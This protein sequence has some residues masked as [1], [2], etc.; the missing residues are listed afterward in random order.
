MFAIDA[1][2]PAS[3]DAMSF[4]HI[5]KLLKHEYGIYGRSLEESRRASA[6]KEEFISSL[7][8]SIDELELAF[9]LIEEGNVSSDFLTE[10]FENRL[11]FLS[12]K[13]AGLVGY[14]EGLRAN[15]NGNAL[16]VGVINE[17][18]PK[19]KKMHSLFVEMKLYVMEARS[20]MESPI[21]Q[22]F[23]SLDDMF[24]HLDS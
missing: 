10:N 9:N 3:A 1:C 15:A 22:S 2:L 20:D 23:E 14:F 16:V 6:E 13:A 12:L 11:D 18:I 19:L 7:N 4:A 17:I 8:V 24:A 5:D 21:S